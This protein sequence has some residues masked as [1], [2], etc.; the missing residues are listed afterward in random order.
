[1]RIKSS[2]K[3]LFHI[4]LKNIFTVRRGAKISREGQQDCLYT[5]KPCWPF[6]LWTWG[7]EAEILDPL[8]VNG[9]C[10][11]DLNGI[12]DYSESPA[13]YTLAFLLL[14]Q[15]WL[16]TPL[17]CLTIKSRQVFYF[18]P[19]ATHF[20]PRKLLFSLLPSR[21]PRWSPPFWVTV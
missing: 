2:V 18:P 10:A 15:Y 12:Q 16:S 5:L 14:T 3:F 7:S 19:P 20:C 13:A 11:V 9:D 1:M 21:T 4:S 6:C 8:E 17:L